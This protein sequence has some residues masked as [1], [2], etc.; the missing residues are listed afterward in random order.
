MFYF[1]YLYI[2]FLQYAI[3]EYATVLKDFSEVFFFLLNSFIHLVNVLFTTLKIFA[4]S[5]WIPW[6]SNPWLWQQCHALCMLQTSHICNVWCINKYI[7]HLF[8][9]VGLHFLSWN[10]VHVANKLNNI[11]PS[12]GVKFACFVGANSYDILWFF[13]R[14]TQIIMSL[15]HY[16]LQ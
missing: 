8:T 6:E 2:C 10:K 4:Y 1:I 7:M 15:E 3:I 12:V 14:L 5:S 11:S 9:D 13:L 16:R